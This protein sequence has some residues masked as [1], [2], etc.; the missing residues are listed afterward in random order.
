M[1]NNEPQD[2]KSGARPFVKWAGGKRQIISELLSHI[3]DSFDRYFEPFVGGG[4]LFFELSHY[5][6]ILVDTSY[7]LINAYKMVKDSV[8]E[9]I[10]L[11]K[12]HE[13]KHCEEHFYRVRGLSTSK[14][15]E[16]DLS[17]EELWCPAQLSPVER[18]ARFIYMNRTCYNGLYRL[19]S[20]GQFNVPYGK[21]KA[22]LICDENN[23]RAAS[24]A[25]S[26]AAIYQDDF[27]SVENEFDIGPGDFIYFDPP[28]VPLSDTSNFT[29]YTKEGFSGE[30]QKRLADMFRRID[31]NG[32]LC[33]LSNS[34]TEPVRSFYEEFN[35]AVV[36]ARRAI[37]SRA[38]DRGEVDELIVKNY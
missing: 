37:N 6:S 33:L 17:D 25:L 32:G 20:D 34:D 27:T 3:P 15:E 35:F 4:A 19:N 7:D 36:K 30:D 38:D 21:Y 22:P 1:D 14:T 9:L 12:E 31:N 16:L 24:R 26:R 5:P 13:K 10:G 2:S 23:L 8:E 18:A 11:L 29:S 28:Y